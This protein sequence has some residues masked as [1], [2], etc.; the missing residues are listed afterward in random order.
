MVFLYNPN[1]QFY[2][3]R[4]YRDDVVPLI[5]GGTYYLSFDL[6]TDLSQ[7]EAERILRKLG[8]QVKFLGLKLK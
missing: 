6:R 2:V 3:V 1:K 5:H 8:E 4:G 7:H